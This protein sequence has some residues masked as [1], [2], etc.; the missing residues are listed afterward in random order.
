MKIFFFK[1]TT[2]LLEKWR[3]PTGSRAVLIMVIIAGQLALVSGLVYFTGGTKF[4][5]VH[6]VYL[7]IISAAA[8]FTAYGGL[9]TAAIGGLLLGPL[10]P[11]DV[12]AHLPQDPTN[13]LLRTIFLI[14][15]GMTAGCIFKLLNRQ[16]DSLIKQAFIDS[17]TGLPNYH[18]LLAELAT[19]QRPKEESTIMLAVL[20]FANRSE[21]IETL[22]YAALK[23]I[24]N[25]IIQ[26][27]DCLE[28]ESGEIRL[29]SGDT[30]RLVLLATEMDQQRFTDICGQCFARV[31]EPVD[32]QGLPVVANVHIGASTASSSTV[33][34]E[35]FHQATIAVR[36]ARKRGRILAWFDTEYDER[37][38]EAMELLG[39][40]QRAISE[41]ELQ[42]YYQAKVN[43]ASGKP[44]GV[45][46]LV[47]WRN[48]HEELIQPARF[49]PQA[50][51]TWLV[52][53]L[54]LFVITQALSQLEQWHNQGIELSIAVN[55]TAANLQSY[56]FIE[57]FK[58]LLMATTCDL[59][60]LE[61][62]ITERTIVHDWQMLADSV[63][64][65]KEMGVTFAIDDF[66]TGFASFAL[67]E[68]L[69]FDIIK[70]DS[71]Y[72]STITTS[73]ISHAFVKGTILIAHE[74]GVK[75]VAEGV[76]TAE[77]ETML[78]EFGCDI[79]QGY[80]F[81]RPLSSHDFN[82]WLQKHSLNQA[83]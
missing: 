22:S 80:F 61:I 74:I 70:L 10:M 47:R 13:W 35:L 2:E 51:K 34:E 25:Q 40:L 26:R 66:G 44:V 53:P 52:H 36:T 37:S 82:T 83:P 9:L 24:N 42:L 5:G 21:I 41:D 32:Y 33:G 58:R 43:L 81:S 79:G 67:F 46:A 64:L 3:K 31:V 55:I 62:E 65:M 4:V 29:F 50:E 7:P 59:A 30:G 18:A 14:L 27:F 48:S 78:R 57:E 38:I 54:T 72:I 49:V 68:R 8:F 56:Y 6:L 77:Q 20:Q 15:V 19:L 16:M 11:L 28:C 76:E 75:I 17:N 73:N 71:S 69:G 63:Q 23:E 39:S 1:L 45:E 12:A 60:C